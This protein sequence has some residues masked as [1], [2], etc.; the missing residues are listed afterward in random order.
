MF[1]TGTAQYIQTLQDQTRIGPITKEEPYLFPSN[2]KQSRAQ[3]ERIVTMTLHLI[4]K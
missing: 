1:V 4:C 2:E 3:I